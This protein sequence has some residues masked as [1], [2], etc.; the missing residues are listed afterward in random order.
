M[1]NRV[2]TFIIGILVGAIITTLIFLIYSKTMN[3]NFR[4]NGFDRN[5][6]REDMHMQMPGENMEEPPAKPDG[7]NM[8]EE[9]I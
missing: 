4:K 5:M 1:K 3:D 6:I 2:L 7:T 8:P 9:K